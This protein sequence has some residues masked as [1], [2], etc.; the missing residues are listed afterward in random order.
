MIGYG[1]KGGNSSTSGFGG[2]PVTLI[3]SEIL[4]KGTINNNGGAGNPNAARGSVGSSPSSQGTGNNHPQVTTN[5]GTG[6]YGA[7][8]GVAGEIKQYLI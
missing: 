2:G 1:G 4:I 3:A 7:N 5:G 8:A 6:G